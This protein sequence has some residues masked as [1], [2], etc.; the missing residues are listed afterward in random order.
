MLWPSLVRLCAAHLCLCTCQLAEW[1]R[2]WWRLHAGGDV[3]CSRGEGRE[4]SGGLGCAG[5][6]SREL[7]AIVELLQVLAWEA[8]G[9]LL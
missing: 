2:A 7:L 4:A 8:L 6:M 5:V 9:P 3:N 1:S